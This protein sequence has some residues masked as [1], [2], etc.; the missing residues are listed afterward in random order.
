[1]K[2]FDVPVFEAISNLYNQQDPSARKE[3]PS[4]NELGTAEPVGELSSAAW[5]MLGVMHDFQELVKQKLAACKQNNEDC[6]NI[7]HDGATIMQS[8]LNTFLLQVDTDLQEAGVAPD[9]R[10]SIC[11]RKGGVIAG[12]SCRA[13]FGGGPSVLVLG[14]PVAV[15]V[16]STH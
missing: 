8:L 1:M 13:R 3:P 16:R 15:D 14:M 11:F 7:L 10:A 4:W 9:V 2:L 5:R 6:A 12:C